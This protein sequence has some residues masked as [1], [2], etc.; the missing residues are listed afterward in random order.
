MEG[1]K[2]ALTILSAALA[3]G[4][5]A[6]CGSG[7]TASSSGASQTEESSV[8]S[9]E[10]SAAA[11]STA[12]DSSASSGA[13]TD[14]SRILVLYFDQGMNSDGAGD[15][16]VDAITSA[17]LSGG[18]P[19]GILQND[20]LVM[21]NE[22]IA[23][24]GADDFPILINETYAPVYEDMV[25]G[26][27]TD[28]EEDRQFTFRNGLP[29]LSDYDT[30]FVGMPVWWG[31]LPQPVVNV[32]EQLDFSGK[33]IVPFGINLGSGFGEMVEQIEEMEPDAEVSADGLTISGHTPNDEAAAA[34]DEWLDGLG[35]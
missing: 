7:S 35:Y 11:E 20:I 6:G 30:V 25:D 21:K 5:L 13:E 22:I 34:V 24:T 14:G 31:S 18:I 15:T 8:S 4:V 33:T 17:S 27:Q 10:S 12:A 2:I 29:D 9:A 19:D 32:F 28:Q 16:E 26:A 23:R 1:K 3:A